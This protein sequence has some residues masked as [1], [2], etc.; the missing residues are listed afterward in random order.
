MY[1]QQP[2]SH[3]ASHRGEQLNE[4]RTMKKA[5]GLLPCSLYK[6]EILKPFF[7]VPF[8]KLVEPTQKMNANPLLP[9]AAP[10]Q[11]RASF[12]PTFLPYPACYSISYQIS[13]EMTPPVRP[14]WRRQPTTAV[15]IFRLVQDV[16]SAL[17][18][19]HEHG[20]VHCDVKSEN[21][22]LQANGKGGY[23]PK[24]TDFGGAMGECVRG[25]TVWSLRSE[26]EKI[27]V[28]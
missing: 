22:L 18:F 24:L 4:L 11:S 17:D 13:L 15:T 3:R 6:R 5:A 20:V 7:D 10:V 27:P 14:I 26:P 16:V 25:L 8:L 2:W 28:Q 23:T 1:L 12:H 19:L 9:Q 21:I